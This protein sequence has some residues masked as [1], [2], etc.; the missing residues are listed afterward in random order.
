MTLILTNPD[1]ESDDVAEPVTHELRGE[2]NE[3]YVET[4]FG[5]EEEPTRAKMV[6]GKVINDDENRIVDHTLVEL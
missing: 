5:N 4:D 2:N 6:N 3:A 1:D